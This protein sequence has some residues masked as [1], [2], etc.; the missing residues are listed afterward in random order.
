MATLRNIKRRIA[1]VRSTQQITRAMKMVAAAKLRK[2]QAQLQSARPY[3]K[4]LQ[5][6]LAQVAGRS[7]KKTHPL[8]EQRSGERVCFVMVTADRGLCG[9]FNANLIR[10]TL[11]EYNQSSAPEKFIFIVG[12]K[13]YDVL[14]RR[15]LPIVAHFIDI[16]HHLEFSTAQKIAGSLMELFLQRKFDRVLI[17]YNEFKSA[18]QQRIVVEQ[19]LPI[20]PISPPEG[21]YAVGF[22]Y[23]PSPERILDALCPLSL[24]IQI[25]R[26]LLESHA[27]E[28]GARMTAMETA[29]ENAED[30]INELV[31]FYN[32]TRQAAITKELNEIVS[33]AEA[34][35]G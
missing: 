29:T 21:R 17:I 19:F 11:L 23:E 10:R 30:M 4:D 31:L 1:S 5:E 2:A 3:A 26:I 27:S 9:S 6:V 8:L 12:R 18:I 25:W 28:L 22:I 34:L 20:Q 35:R 16:F 14:R 13:G 15:N 24:N 7:K 33:G 32:K